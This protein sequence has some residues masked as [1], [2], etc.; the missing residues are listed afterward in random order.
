MILRSL[1]AGQWR[2][3]VEPVLA[4]PFQEGLNVIFAP[5]G[6]GKST[7]FEALCRGL[8]D[9]HRVTGRDVEALRPWGRSLA[10]RVTIEFQQ[11]GVEYRVSK[12]FLDRPLARLE[13]KEGDRFL[14][15]AESDRADEQVRAM[16][17][18]SQPGRGLAQRK[19]WGLAQV[20]WAPQGSLTFE[21]LSGD[22]LADIRTMLGAQVSG[23]KLGRLE[24]RIEQKYL[25][26][27][28]PGGRLR[29]GREAPALI[30][31][32]ERLKEAREKVKSAR[33]LHQA[34]EQAS[35]LVEDC[36]AR[37]E[38][39]SR[40]IEELTRK[41]EQVRIEAAGYQALKSE[42]KQREEQLKSAEARY[43]ELKQR[44]DLIRKREEE[45]RRIQSELDS[46]GERLSACAR[47]HQAREKEMVQAKAA[48]EDV[49]RTRTI[50]DQAERKAEAAGR[51]QG[52]M[53]KAS[54]LAGL[55]AKVQDAEES[56][57]QRR[58]ERGGVIVPDSRE[59]KVIR[60][61]IEEKA[62]ARLKIE[63]ALITLEIVPQRDFS[64]QIVAAEETG[65]RKLVT[66]SPV[67]LKGS[68][69]VVADIEG[70]A[71]LRA[72][73]PAGSIEQHRAELAR[74]EARLAEKTGPYGT[75]DPDRL[76]QMMDKARALEAL[77]SEA[78]TRLKTMLGDKR[79]EELLQEQAAAEAE[80][81]RILSDYPEWTPDPPEP[82][83]LKSE[84]ERLKTSFIF[85]VEAAEA[86][87]SKAQTAFSE[88]D[89]KRSGLEQNL[90]AGRKRN[91]ALEAELAEL[92]KDGR[93]PEEREQ[94]LR[95]LALDYAAAE[96]KLKDLESKLAGFAEDPGRT[97]TTLERQLEAAR[98]EVT[99]AIESESVEQGRLEHL[100]GQ[101]PYSR[102]VQA[103]EEAAWLEAAV[104]TERLRTQAVQLLYETM[105]S[106]RTEA[107]AAVSKPVETA[108]SRLFSRIAG[109]RLG[110]LRVDET[111]Q[112]I[113]VGPEFV[114][115][116]VSIANL[117]GGESEQLYL[118]TRLALALVLARK[119]RQ[120][121]VLDDV[122]TAT[123]AGRL[124]RVMNVL[125]E[126]AQHLQI[127]IL[128]CHP[129]RYRGLAS[130]LFLDLE[131][132][133]S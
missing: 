50:I 67:R 29:S 81:G 69:E 125:E 120:L 25:S 9:G 64:L 54:E 75:D 84:A 103:E 7:L 49:R 95:R 55:L 4:G 73:G 21:S 71:R 12:Q 100:A 107:V 113:T 87:W 15:V 132:G 20:L 46:L 3:F 59:M 80:A 41:L 18:Q 68:P 109:G 123:D 101:G 97:A 112:P 108:A 61:L 14:P 92:T 121:V 106:C 77:T 90:E 102:L 76:E 131:R 94:E 17:T 33:E 51:Y 10:P 83:R 5:N 43:H 89:L 44:T 45:K 57:A 111:F 122:L 52:L 88:A 22:L 63:A 78:E 124:A 6:T 127:L 27:F 34:W 79:R 117:S 128:T 53:K 30:G 48:L 11:A 35:R 129:E 104:E 28:T 39:I 82:V 19:H 8:L 36:R 126:A 116:P 85:Q 2:C 56:L 96:E 91:V 93:R 32:E 119:E 133:R 74:A 130:A 118:A 105:I 24:A 42:N 110:G 16:L 86:E 98:Q 115:E 72:W 114:D 60:K 23:P 62:A 38:H 1:T 66:G 47:E 31:L 70:L 26:F 65:E 58:A 40:N 99:R 13:R 37:R